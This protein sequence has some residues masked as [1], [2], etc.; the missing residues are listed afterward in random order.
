LKHQFAEANEE[1]ERIEKDEQK[2]AL[3]TEEVQ[4]K[5]NISRKLYGHLIQAFGGWFKGELFAISR[6]FADAQ[7]VLFA[8]SLFLLSQA[9]DTGNMLILRQ[10]NEPSETRHIGDMMKAF[11]GSAILG[12]LVD[13]WRIWTVIVGGVD[14]SQNV[15]NLQSRHLLTAKLSWLES[16]PTSRILQRL[17]TD[18]NVIDTALFSR[19]M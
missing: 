1:T 3:Y 5:G 10:M 15:Y 8:V 11:V 17:S 16:V 9:L 13:W 12:F 2:D 7:P 4:N 18:Q 6:R 19:I 14:A